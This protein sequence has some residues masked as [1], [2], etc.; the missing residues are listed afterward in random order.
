MLLSPDMGGLATK[1]AQTM[2]FCPNLPKNPYFEPFLWPNH[3]FAGLAKGG[4]LLVVSR[5]I[6]EYSLDFWTKIKSKTIFGN[7]IMSP[8]CWLNQFFDP[9]PFL[10]IFDHFWPFLSQFWAKLGLNLKKELLGFFLPV[11]VSGTL[12]CIIGVC[13]TKGCSH[14]SPCRATR[15]A[16]LGQKQPKRTF[17]AISSTFGHFYTVGS[18]LAVFGPIWP[19]W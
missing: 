1:M 14:M 9:W 11:K 6:C 12:V 19:F 4:H 8:F 15:M 10:A 7:G 2:G 17:D 3:P 16:K 13:K 5:L 18:F